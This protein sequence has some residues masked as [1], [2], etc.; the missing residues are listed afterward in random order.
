M[1]NFKN[2]KL[3]SFLPDVIIV[4]L[5]SILIFLNETYKQKLNAMESDSPC[6][7][8]DLIPPSISENIRLY[9]DKI[10]IKIFFY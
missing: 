4:Y 5:F 9:F 7:I 2:L 3:N 1:I 6:F 8:I 10:L